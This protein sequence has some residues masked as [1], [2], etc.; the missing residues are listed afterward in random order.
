MRS[1][2]RGRGRGNR[3]H[4]WDYYTGWRGVLPKGCLV[5]IWYFSYFPDPGRAGPDYQLQRAATDR[6]DRSARTLVL[7]N[8]CVLCALCGKHRFRIRSSDVTGC[9]FLVP[10]S[11][12]PSLD[13]SPQRTWRGVAATNGIEQ[14]HRC[15]N[16]CPTSRYR[17]ADVPGRLKFAQE[18]K[19]LNVSSTENGTDG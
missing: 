17:K 3:A 7:S 15:V 13:Y 10:A 14:K 4:H 8:L 5:S 9:W 16:G 11:S 1:S 6:R 12:C 19:I 2:C 18:D